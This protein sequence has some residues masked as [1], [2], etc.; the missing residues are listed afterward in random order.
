MGTWKIGYNPIYV[1]ANNGIY[2]KKLHCVSSGG[3]NTH[4]RC[5]ASPLLAA[6]TPC[7]VTRAHDVFINIR[8]IGHVL[9]CPNNS[10]YILFGTSSSSLY[11]SRCVLATC[12]IMVN[13]SER[14]HG[15]YSN[16]TWAQAETIS[17]ILAK[18]MMNRSFENDDDE[19]FDKRQEKI[20]KNNTFTHMHIYI[21]IYTTII[22]SL[23]HYCYHD[24]PTFQLC[25][26]V[27]ESLHFCRDR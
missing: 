22:L 13:P 27:V 25:V 10:I 4:H 19:V 11:F 21:Y 17:E 23:K 24:F 14:Q 18:S 9:S 8:F 1:Y 16:F 3:F 12:R 5:I 26:S 7:P 6:P 2:L 20:K 15:I